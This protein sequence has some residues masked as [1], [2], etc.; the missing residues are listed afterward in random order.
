MQSSSDSSSEQ[1]D[2]EDLK[3]A[4]GPEGAEEGGD[5]HKPWYHALGPGLITGAADVDP[6]NIGT[7]SIAGAQYGY[8]MAWMVPL[9]VPLMI[10]VQEMCGRIG[11]VTGKGLAA[12]IKEHYPRWLLYGVVLLLLIANVT[13][14]YADLNVIAA[15]AQMLWHGPLTLWLVLFTLLIAGLQILVR[16]RIYVR[17]LKWLCLALLTYVVVALLPSVHKDWGQIARGLVVPSWNWSAPFL[18]TITGILGTSIS[19]YLLFWQSGEEVEEEI[20]EGK[21]TAPGHRVKRVRKK[22]L[23]DLKIDTGV[24][25]FGSQVV[26]FFILVCAAAT[27]H[28]QGKPDINTAQDAAIA[29]QPI[30]QAAYWLFTI[31]VLG[32]GMLAIP[33][34]AGSVAYAVAEVAGWRYGFYRRF[35]RA[36]GFYLTIAAVVLLGFL[37]NFVHSLSPMKALLYSAALNGVVAPPLLIVLLM[38]CNNRRVVGKRVNGWLSNLVGITTVV[39]MG[40]ASAFLLWAM[41]TGR[42]N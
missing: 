5:V 38:L 39:L 29:L 37:L 13:N 4:R 40:A 31:G 33:T 2:A 21:A 7:Y 16:Y 3:N 27:L 24:G 35:D 20:A 14:I 25:M 12:V 11:V 26:T 30:G 15:S 23:R 6:S 28:A 22:E 41:A 19:P 9:C 8:T 32:S 36:R 10:A 18:L 34:L 17:L 42:A 1:E